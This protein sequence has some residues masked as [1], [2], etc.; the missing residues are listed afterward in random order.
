MPLTKQK[1]C[2]IENYLHQ[3][4]D[5]IFSSDNDK[6][7]SEIREYIDVREYALALDDMAAITKLSG[8]PLTP[9]LRN[10]FEAAAN[11]ME[12]KPGDNE[13]VR[14]NELIWPKHAK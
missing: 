6:Y 10:L 14:I 3:I 2:I 4:S 7:R 11:K 1:A 5:Q 9:K 8:K 13:C 12:I